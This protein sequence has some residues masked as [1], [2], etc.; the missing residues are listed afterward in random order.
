[1]ELGRR[2]GVPRAGGGRPAVGRS[3]RPAEQCLAPRAGA[4]GA[5]L[6]G[7]SS[8]APLVRGRVRGRRRRRVGPARRAAAQL[9]S[10]SR[11][12]ARPRRTGPRAPLRGGRRG[13]RLRARHH[14]S[15]AARP[16]GSPAGAR[17]ADRAT[18]RG[19]HLRRGSTPEVAWDRK[20]TRLNSIHSQ[21]SYAV[22]GLE[23]KET[24]TL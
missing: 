4:P 5:A 8:A 18:R 6:A 12:S 20:S 17:A 1:P 15:A 19:P 21:I 24:T 3:A 22:F 7:A 16:L 14:G 23:Q 9:A 2:G 10:G 11:R 13:D